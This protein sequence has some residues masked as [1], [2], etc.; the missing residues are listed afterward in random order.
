MKK[1][2]CPLLFKRF[3]N[4][5]YDKLSSHLNEMKNNVFEA[6]MIVESFNDII[7]SNIKRAYRTA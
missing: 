3:R 4:D 7:G 2:L 5:D 6:L 1:I